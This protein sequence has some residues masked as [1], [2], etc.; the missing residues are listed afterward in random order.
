MEITA[1][2]TVAAIVAEDYKTASIFRGYKIDFC[3]NGNRAIADVTDE[4]KIDLEQLIKELHEVSTETSSAIDYQSWS[5]DFMVDYIYQNH[6]LYVEKQVP[7]I[8]SYLE[9]IC[10][11]HGERHPELYEIKTLFRESAGELTAHMKKEELMLFPAIKK[12]ARAQKEGNDLEGLPFG[13]IQNPINRMHHE[14]DDEGE[15]F[16]KMRKLSNDYTAPSDG[17]NT[18][19]VAFALLEAFETDLH[20]HIH[21]ENNILFKKAIEVEQE[22]MN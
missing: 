2:T 9:K 10:S 14:H 1:H 17:C 18:Y 3:C 5:L 21:L 19:K 8:L 4:K 15:R 22:L 6:H 13:T 20:K 11:A 7:E 12:I 16:R